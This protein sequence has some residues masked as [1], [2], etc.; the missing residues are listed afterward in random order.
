MRP[1]EQAPESRLYICVKKITNYIYKRL[2]TLCSYLKTKESYDRWVIR[3]FWGYRNQISK[4]K[5]L[6]MSVANIAKLE[7]KFHSRACNYSKWLRNFRSKRTTFSQQK[8]DFAAVQNFPLAWSDRLPIP[9]TPSFQVWIVH[10]LKHW[11]V[12]FLSF[13]TTYSMHKLDSRKCSKSCLHDCH[14]ECFLADFSL[15]PLLAFR[16]CLWQRTSKL[17]LFMFLSLP[18]LCHG[19][20]RTLFNLGLLW[21]SNY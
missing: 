4:A 9:V 2:F 7:E 13:E 17:Q 19:F 12:D 16:I 18:L 20:Q 15:L 1:W 21:W 8:G 6:K 10:H 11:I 3:R 5:N 14:Q